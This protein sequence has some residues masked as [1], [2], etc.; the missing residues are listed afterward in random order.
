M[1]KTLLVTCLLVKNRQAYWLLMLY[2]VALVLLVAL[3]VTVSAPPPRGV[4]PFTKWEAIEYFSSSVII[5]LLF[6]VLVL[7]RGCVL[8]D[9]E[10]ERELLLANP[11]SMREYFNAHAL[12]EAITLAVSFLPYGMFIA[13]FTNGCNGVKAILLVIPTLTFTYFFTLLSGVLAILTINKIL[14]FLIHATITVYAAASI[15]HSLL[16]LRISPLLSMPFTPLVEPIILC[17]TITGEPTQVLLET[18]PVLAAT[19]G[20]VLVGV[21][22]ADLIYPENLKLPVELQFTSSE[23]E[24]IKPIYSS[25]RKAIYNVIL[26]RPLLSRK[27]LTAATLAVI[28]PLTLGYGLRL[29]EAQLSSHIISNLGLSFSFLFPMVINAQVFAVASALGPI[30][31]YRVNLA[32][33]KALASAFSLRLTLYCSE[34]CLA[35]SLFV[36]VITGRARYLLLPLAALPAATASATVTLIILAY[37]MS[38]KRLARRTETGLTLPE[39]MLQVVLFAST[40]F[41]IA[42]LVW[43]LSLIE[44]GAP[45]LFYYLAVSIAI[46]AI[47]YF[48]GVELA[49]E[50]LYARDVAS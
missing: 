35:F 11:I 31:V 20:I 15:T 18:L 7:G 42:P 19:A 23:E 32:D 39:E 12:H 43:F 4:L 16:T 29:F 24:A 21:H 10:A 47:V 5:T 44:S 36:A 40:A 37:V 33:M 25:P 28:A 26:L 41:L 38:K 14:R 2:A 34:V 27:H 45:W 17:F 50:L 46:A 13:F 8:I 1:K 49:S 6:T 9:S 48:L 3:T 30:W 22:L